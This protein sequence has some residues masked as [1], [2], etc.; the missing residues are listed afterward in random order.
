[1]ER[2]CIVCGDINL[3][4]R[5]KFCCDQCKQKYYYQKNKVKRAEYKKKDYQENK[6]EYIDRA[7]DWQKINRDRWNEYQKEYQ[8]RIRKLK[9]GE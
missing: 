6:Q 2:K 4:P 5:S 1:M 9:K 3:T 7:L 8:K